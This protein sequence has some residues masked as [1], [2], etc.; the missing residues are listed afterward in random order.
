MNRTSCSCLAAFGLCLM[1]SVHAQTE[2]AKGRWSIGASSWSGVAYRS[3]LNNDGSELAERIIVGRN[4]RERPELTLGGGFNA[5]YRISQRLSLEAGVAYARFGYAISVNL[6]DL[7]FGDAIDPR[8]GFIYNT[9]DHALPSSWRFIDRFH[10]L[11]VPI[12]L[13]MELG[14]GRWRSSTTLGVAPAF[15]LAAQGIT[16]SEYSDGRVERESF[17]PLEEFTSFNLIPYFSTG[18]SMHPGGR[19]HWSMRPTFR[20]GALKI[21]DAPLSARVYS[22]TLDLGVGFRIGK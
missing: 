15:L 22:L 16:V 13:V 18:L 21:I 9:G 17:E 1:G 2:A 7:T 14:E 20:Y 19:W 8:R 4:D 11:E 12:G 3:L 10:Y 5:A 6:S